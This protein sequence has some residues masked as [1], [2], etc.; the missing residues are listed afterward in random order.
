MLIRDKVFLVTGGGSG[1]GAAVARALVADGASVVIA[2]IN[3][4]AGSAIAAELG[5]KTRFAPTDVTSE[6]EGEAAVAMALE[7]FGHL[8][9][10]VNCAGIAPGEKVLGRDGPHRLDSFA[11]AIGINLVGTFNMI[12]LAAAA[13]AKEEPDDG[14]ARGVIINTASVAAFDGQIGQAAYSASKGGVVAMT[15]PIARELAR[16]GIR[17]VSIAPGI[18]ETPMMAGMPQEVQD[19]LGKSVPFPP[20]LGRPDEYA[21]LVRHICEND[22]LNGEVIRLDGA[23]RMGAR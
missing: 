1:L 21:A 9:G 23:L 16:F 7:S 22:M 18:F 20:R 12:R 6:A 19:S 8:H 4:D 5:A 2:D 3:S 10:L 17:V 15:L 14:G 13:I 11:R